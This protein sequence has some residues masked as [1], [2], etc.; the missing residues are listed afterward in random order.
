MQHSMPQPTGTK[1][2]VALV[3]AALA[4][5]TPPRQAWAASPLVGQAASASAAAVGGSAA[6]DLAAVDLAAV[7]L[8]AASVGVWAASATP[9]VQPVKASASAATA[10]IWCSIPSPD[11]WSR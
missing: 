11:E 7:D 6:V 9:V 2:S 5:A 3:G 10:P 1:A 4:Q 8:A